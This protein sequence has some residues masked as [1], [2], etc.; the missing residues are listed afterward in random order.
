M[1]LK[2]KFENEVTVTV[3]SGKTNEVLFDTTKENAISDD[4]LCPT[5]SIYRTVYVEVVRLIAFLTRW[6]ELDWLCF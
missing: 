5:G 2:P 1:N 4:F 3:R 6:T